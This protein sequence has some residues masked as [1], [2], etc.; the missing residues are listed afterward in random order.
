MTARDPASN[1]K[2]TQAIPPTAIAASDTNGAAILATDYEYLAVVVSGPAAASATVTVR[3]QSSATSG[4]TFADIAT[5]TMTIDENGTVIVGELRMLHALPET[6]AG[7]PGGQPWIRAV[8]LG[9]GASSGTIAVNY[10]GTLKH[11]DSNFASKAPQT[12]GFSINA[13]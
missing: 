10:V 7:T 2:I 13:T 8:A 6:V 12:Y 4:G 11:I 1:L 5:A 9:S 3:I